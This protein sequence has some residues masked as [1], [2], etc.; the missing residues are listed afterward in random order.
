MST[1]DLAPWAEVLIFMRDWDARKGPAYGGYGYPVPVRRLF[2]KFGERAVR[3]RLMLFVGLGELTFSGR[4]RNRTARLTPKG[5]GV[6]K[7]LPLHECPGHGRSG[8]AEPC[9]DRKGEYNGFGSD[10]P[11]LFTCPKGCSC[12]D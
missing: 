10:G 1:T 6:A 7:L 9:C 4:G 2:I 5:M 8:T 11:R 3:S 12:H